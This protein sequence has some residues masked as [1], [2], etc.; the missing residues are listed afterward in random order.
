LRA[1]A[2][3]RKSTGRRDRLSIDLGTESMPELEP[4][5]NA[6]LRLCV[7]RHGR[8]LG[9]HLR[10]LVRGIAEQGF[11]HHRD[12]EQDQRVGERGRDQVLQW[13][14]G[15]RGGW[16]VQR[17]RYKRSVTVDVGR[18]HGQQLAHPHPRWR[19]RLSVW[20]SGEYYPACGQFY[21][22]PQFKYYKIRRF[23][24]AFLPGW[25]QIALKPASKGL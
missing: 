9:Q 5:T 2:M 1:L 4:G 18:Y 19:G 6:V 24:P 23:T 16:L 17:V 10:E 20:S 15:R 7:R 8:L 22:P 25:V 11:D 12:N 13:V 21:G 14:G 3:Y